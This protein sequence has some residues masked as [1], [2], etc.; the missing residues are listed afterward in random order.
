MIR[1]RFTYQGKRK[2]L[3][4]GLEHNRVNQGLAHGIA[5]QIESDIQCNQLDPTLNKYRPKTIGNAGLKCCELFDKFTKHKQRDLGVST[6]SVETRY[7]PL[8]RALAQWLDIPAHEVNSRDSRDFAA[9]QLDRVTGRTA[10]ERI[11]LL[12]ACWEWGKDEGLLSPDNLNPW[13]GLQKP[14]KSQ[15]RESREP[16]TIAELQA[17]LNGFATHRQFRW[18]H[19]YVLFLASVGCRPGEASA[20]TWGDVAKDFG[21]VM[22]SKSFSRGN[23]GSTKTGKSRVVVLPETVQSMLSERYQQAALVNGQ[24]GKDSLVFPSP[25][26]LPICDRN[27]RNRAWKTILN[28]CNVPYRPPYNLR[29]SAISHA[30]NHGNN[31]AAIAEQTG[32]NLRT[33]LGTYAHAVGKP[34]VFDGIDLAGNG[35]AE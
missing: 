21:T 22:I 14:I 26:G 15:P 17:I 5:R 34:Q 16:F 20:L 28:E 33:M 25:K 23:L 11:G 30:L 35:G 13:I 4:L 18:Y 32:H 19:D 10:K 7:V 1:L 31:P 8:S 29:H 2:S 6:R 3:S 9:V 12:K 27:F 24:P